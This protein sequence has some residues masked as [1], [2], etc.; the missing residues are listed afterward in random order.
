M[1]VSTNA[2]ISYGYASTE[3]SDNCYDLVDKYENDGDVEVG[4]HCHDEC[5]MLYV[6]LRGTVTTASRGYPEK[7]LDFNVRYTKKQLDKL[8]KVAAEIGIEG[9]DLKEPSWFICSYWG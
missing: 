4:I 2:I 5:S 7:N 3:D 1:G 6:G 8:K 9:D